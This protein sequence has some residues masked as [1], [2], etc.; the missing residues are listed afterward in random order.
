MVSRSAALASVRAIT[1][2]V[3]PQTSAA[4]RAAISFCTA[5]WLG[6]STLPPMW[7]ALF[8]GR[9]LIFEA[10]AGGARFNHPFISSKAFSTP[11]KP[12]SASA[13]MGRK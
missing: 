8:H 9:E 7:A 11:P 1:R 10:Y 12:A 2:V 4:R 6:T 5:S 3:V 13:T